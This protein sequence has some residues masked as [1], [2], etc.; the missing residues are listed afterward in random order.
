MKG[1]VSE[2][3]QRVPLNQKTSKHLWSSSR[4]LA[5]EKLV[6]GAYRCGWRSSPIP[7]TPVSLQGSLSDSMGEDGSRDLTCEDYYDEGIPK[8][9]PDLHEVEPEEAGA[10]RWSL[11]KKPAP[12]GGTVRHSSEEYND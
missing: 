11:R 8:S 1:S 12:V 10:L 2:S 9:E 5:E 7:P 6:E 3:H 4:L